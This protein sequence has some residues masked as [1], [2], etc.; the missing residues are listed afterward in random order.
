VRDFKNDNSSDTDAAHTRFTP[1][2]AP[3]AGQRLIREGLITQEEYDRIYAAERDAWNDV[4]SMDEAALDVEL[5]KDEAAWINASAVCSPLD[6]RSVPRPRAPALRIVG[7][8][9]RTFTAAPYRSHYRLR[10]AGVKDGLKLSTAE[11]DDELR[12][13][14]KLLMATA[15]CFAPDAFLGLRDYLKDGRLLL[16]ERVNRGQTTLQGCVAYEQQDVR[17]PDGGGGLVKHRVNV[18]SLLAV[19][20]SEHPAKLAA[21]GS[22]HRAKLAVRLALEAQLRGTVRAMYRGDGLSCIGTLGVILGM[23][24]RALTWAERLGHRVRILG[25]D[26][27]VASNDRTLTAFRDQFAE[28]HVSPA[29]RIPYRFVIANRTQ[30]LEAAQRHVI[31]VLEYKVREDEAGL[32]IDYEIDDPWAPQVYKAAKDLVARTPDAMAR[33][34]LLGRCGET[35]WGPQ[36]RPDM[37]API[38]PRPNDTRSGVRKSAAA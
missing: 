12:D 20:K 22:E 26:T 16:V 30:L 11:T 21:R 31:G 7:S 3:S 33:F 15:E 34:G 2:D 18:I 19:Q 28:K 5:G 14:R 25:P 23:N 4:L 37:A 27:R 36:P 38:R 10:L 17:C 8:R 32:R 9:A 6:R 29:R 13:V 35:I 1:R 24:D